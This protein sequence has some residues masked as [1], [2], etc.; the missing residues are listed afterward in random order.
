MVKNYILDTNVIIHDPYCFYNFEDNNIILPIV[1]IEELD[2]VKN[3]EGMVGYHAR[4][5]AREL[6]NLRERGNLEQGIKTDGGGTI[7]IE[8]DHMDM[9]CIPFGI[10]T[11]K[12]DTRILAMAKNLQNENRDIPTILVTKDV[13]M[14][15]KADSFGIEVQDYHNDKIKSDEVYTGYI[16]IYTSSEKI[17]LVY[18]GGLPVEELKLEEP[19]I[20]NQFL[21][22]TSTD[23]DNH[24]VLARFD[25][26]NI[27]PLKYAKNSAWGLTPINMEQKMA[28]ELLMDKDIPFVTITG[29]AGSGKTILATA[30]A[31]EKVIEQGEYSKI[32]FVRPTVA[33]GNDIGYLPGTEEEKLRPWMG[34]FYDAI[35]NLMNVKINGS[36]DN[37]KN[38]RNTGKPEFSVDNFI[39]TYRMKGVIETKTF[40]Y[41]RGRT[42]SNAMVIVDE[43]QE[44]TPHLAKLMLTRAGFG[45][46]FVF[47]GDPTDN[48]IDNV[49]VDAKSNGLVY[50]VE[51]MKEFQITGH[52]ALKQVERSPLASIAERYM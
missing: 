5:A 22:I 6:N 37:S 17:N 27:I 3:R 1:A 52:V 49:L 7:R 30:V 14:A 47:I 35:G 25:G 28:F 4:M 39:E 46:K 48:Q 51:K 44:L 34:S 33:A 41:M 45:S 18:K 21:Y 2:N 23:D 15:I 40:T 8:M 10:D 12:N 36:G 38:S 20:P 13:Y 32:V 29:G 42:L 11:N 26:K 9:S 43:A 50:T 31:L 24:K 16:S 19:L